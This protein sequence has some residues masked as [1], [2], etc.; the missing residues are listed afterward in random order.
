MD[1]LGALRK[2]MDITP[3]I[4]QCVWVKEEK[5]GGQIKTID[6]KLDTS[7]INNRSMIHI[8]G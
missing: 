8:G 4:R 2:G 1:I 3:L 6:K 7:K 5:L